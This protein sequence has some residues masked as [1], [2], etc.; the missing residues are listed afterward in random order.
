M[1]TTH[2]HLM[3]DFVDG[4]T[5]EITTAGG[6]YGLRMTR[7]YDTDADDLWS[8]WTDPSRMAR[9]L[10]RPDGEL[11][12]GGE[13]TLWMG[14][15]DDTTPPEGTDDVAHLQVLH[16]A[17][18]ERLT[19]RW[20]WSQDEPSLV[21]LR[22]TP[23]GEG[24]TLLELDHVVLDRDGATG[25]G[26]GWE[27]FL[28]RLE[29]SLAGRPTDFASIEPAVDPLWATA[30]DQAYPAE[31]PAVTSTGDTSTLEA[32]RWMAA[33][34]DAV[35]ER[36][37]TRSGLEQ[38]YVNAVSGDLAVGGRFRCVFDQ[39][40][41]TGE[42]LTCTPEREL[43]VTWQWAGV[44]HTS[45][46][47]VAL[48]PEVRDGLPGTRVTWREEDASGNVEAYAAGLHSHLVGLDRASRGLPS[49]P[50]RW[51]ADFVSAF[52]QLTGRYANPFG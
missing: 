8:A 14:G 16:C 10:G 22:L 1:T 37:S 23:L 20:A 17:R 29:A 5:R 46:M 31:L 42:V 30:G 48:A 51:Y 33:P 36:L 40:E 18:P 49:T 9:W 25:Y 12:E 4:T 6:R 41:A 13:V 15:P 26:S 45:R 50:T 52:S 44:S 3:A 28:A 19:V 32:E 7:T 47:T 24:Q 38:W 35:W 2:D 34:P 39:G 11:R 21:D 43:V 27:D